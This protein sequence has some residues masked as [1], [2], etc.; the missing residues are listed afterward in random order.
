MAEQCVLDLV[1]TMMQGQHIAG[2]ND[3]MFVFVPK[4]GGGGTAE[5]TTAEGTRPLA[6]K[7]SGSGVKTATAVV[8]RSVRAVM[9]TSVAPEQRGFVPGRDITNNIWE[10]DVSMRALVAE[11]ADE[12]E[13]QTPLLLSL[14]INDAFPSVLPEWMAEAL[15]ATGA[16][17]EV[18]Q[19]V[20]AMYAGSLAKYRTEEAVVDLPTQR[21]GVAQGC[22]ASGGHFAMAVDTPLRMLS[23][24]VRAP[25]LLRAGADDVAAACRGPST[26]EAMSPLLNDIAAAIGLGIHPTK[27]Q[28]VP[29]GRAEDLAAASA[30]LRA[31]LEA[32]A[33]RFARVS[34]FGLVRVLG[35]SLG[36]GRPHRLGGSLW[37]S[38]AVEWWRSALAACR[39]AL[40]PCSTS[41]PRSQPSASWRSWSPRRRASDKR[42]SKCLHL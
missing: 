25:G 19:F 33:P 37:R 31:R 2:L 18:R 24:A 21:S 8:S 35:L 5:S 34:V 27:T 16:P 15:A 39:S 42:R 4:A 13:A 6:L 7:N 22:P 11:A 12:P 23:D 9:T 32:S 41:R 30:A 29:A 14:D 17:A 40:R 38:G 1:T 10:L 36:R 3:A 28:L 20:A 26:V